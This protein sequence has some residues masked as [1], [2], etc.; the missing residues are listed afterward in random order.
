MTALVATGALTFSLP[1]EAASDFDTDTAYRLGAYTTRQVRFESGGVELV[2][3]LYAPADTTGPQPGVVLL[4][5]FGSI[6]EQSPMEYAT[7]L[8]RDGFVTLIFDPRYSGESGGEPRRLESPKAKIEDVRAALDFL[9]RQPKVDRNRLA[10]LGIC[11]GSSEMLAVAAIDPR[12][13]ALATVS[14]QYLY[15]SNIDGF[16]GGGGP[17]REQRIARGQDAKAKYEKTGEV[18]YTEVVSATDK[19][20]GLPWKPIYDWYH[21][22]TTDKWLKPSR[23]ENRYATM[24]DA[25]VW[26]FDVDTQAARVKVPTL[27]IHVRISAKVTDDFGNVTGLSG[28]C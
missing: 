21:P 22:W 4:G 26:S 9:E 6:K 28:E 19:S 2:G 27:V 13:K 14:G 8:A 7:R 10:A 12:V 17:R 20:A 24:S 18:A 25:E 23:W 11:Q 1:V 5:P 3:L 16:F 15:A